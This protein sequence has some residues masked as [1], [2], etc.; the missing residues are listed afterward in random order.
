ML[1]IYTLG[2]ISALSLKPLILYLLIKFVGL[3]EANEM[4]VVFTAI[5][6]AMVTLNT[7]VYR[8][9]YSQF[10]LGKSGIYAISGFLI[11]TSVMSLI[12]AMVLF[13]L[14]FLM[15]QNIVNAL[16]ISTLYLSEKL[17]DESLRFKLFQ[18]D[19]AGWGANNLGRGL[20]SILIIGIFYLTGHLNTT[21]ILIV[22]S[23][24]NIIIF[25]RYVPLAY[26]TRV[27]KSKAFLKIIYRRGLLYNLKHK[28]FLLLALF[29]TSIGY[30]DR[31]LSLGIAQEKLTI[32]LL[33]IMCCAV[34]QQLFD[35][36][37]FSLRRKDFI[38]GAISIK[39]SLFSRQL[40]VILSIGMS[41]SLIAVYIILA[42]TPGSELVAWGD[43]IGI[44][45]FQLTACL[46]CLAY[47]ILY[48][49]DKIKTLITVDLVFWLIFFVVFGIVYFLELSNPFLVA[50]IIYLI[51]FFY[52]TNIANKISSI[53][54]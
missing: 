13:C 11:G 14:Y 28:K 45:T 26:F 20:C 9:F 54:K 31:I 44:F 24:V 10:F 2:R 52:L 12:G 46:S 29:S 25:S 33:I 23:M 4:A 51:R 3:D 49:N 15:T 18:K 40:W 19:F 36:Y 34:M 47:Q 38:T 5:T 27:F 17:V 37:Y 53:I 50:A 6:I 1:S 8:N 39:S 7:D 43:L 22:M 35:Y 21:N 41:V 16:L 42:T 48:W 30:L 32:L